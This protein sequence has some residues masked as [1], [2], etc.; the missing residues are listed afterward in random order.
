MRL[1]A[2]SLFLPRSIDLFRSDRSIR[3]D[4]PAVRYL[5][6]YICCAFCPSFSKYHRF[7]II[8]VTQKQPRRV[9]ITYSISQQPVWRIKPRSDREGKRVGGKKIPGTCHSPAASALPAFARHG[10]WLRVSLG[11]TVT[12]KTSTGR[13]GKQQHFDFQLS[14]AIKTKS[15]VKIELCSTLEYFSPRH[16]CETQYMYICL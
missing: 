14:I 15:R 4:M 13:R 16:L 9:L 11:P 12:A 10:R 3:S 5:C 1:V 2:S 7:P 8:G 6:C